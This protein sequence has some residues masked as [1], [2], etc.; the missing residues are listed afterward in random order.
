MHG[1]LDPTLDFA[2]IDHL[3]AGYKPE[4]PDKLERVRHFAGVYHAHRSELQVQ[5]PSRLGYEACWV[6]VPPLLELEQ[7]VAYMYVCIACAGRDK[8][9]EALQ[10]HHWW[11]GM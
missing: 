9:L 10:Q 3:W 6:N 8:L 11:P 4:D 2:L 5:A 1:S 7:L